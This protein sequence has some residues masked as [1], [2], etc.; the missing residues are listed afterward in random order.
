[1]HIGHGIQ[2]LLGIEN[3]IGD[4]SDVVVTQVQISDFIQRVYANWPI[5]ALRMPHID[6]A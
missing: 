1:M 2:A 5:C 4:L 3:R 6:M